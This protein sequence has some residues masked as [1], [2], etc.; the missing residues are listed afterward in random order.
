MPANNQK[1][2]TAAQSS[3]APLTYEQE[4]HALLCAAAANTE[5]LIGYFELQADH[6]TGEAKR[7]TNKCI[8]WKRED[9]RRLRALIPQ[10]LEKR[11]AAKQV[12]GT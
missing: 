3:V 7:L 9:L 8:D 11:D 6:E 1:I 2:V 4:V 12:S 5:S 10:A